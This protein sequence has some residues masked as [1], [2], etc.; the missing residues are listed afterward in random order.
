MSSFC[1]RFYFTRLAAA[2]VT[3]RSPAA[4]DGSRYCRKGFF[5]IS[6]LGNA[7]RHFSDFAS[8]R[9]CLHIDFTPRAG[10]DIPRH[11]LPMPLEMPNINKEIDI[12]PNM[13]QNHH[14]RFT[15]MMIFFMQQ[16]DIRDARTGMMK[17]LVSRL[18]ASRAC[19]PFLAINTSHD[20]SKLTESL[21]SFFSAA[22]PPA[23]IPFYRDS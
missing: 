23:E 17:I 13:A 1:L 18:L 6:F 16:E 21:I 20:I 5:A 15:S 19:R 22:T 11:T 4:R 12:F 3:E 2:R 8:R 7:R 14:L 9:P 10:D